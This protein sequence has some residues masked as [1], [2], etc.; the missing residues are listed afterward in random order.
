[1]L[2]IDMVAKLHGGGAWDIDMDF[3]NCE[4]DGCKTMKDRQGTREEGEIR[5]THDRLCPLWTSRDNSE[6]TKS[7]VGENNLNRNVDSACFR[8][9]LEKQDPYSESVN[10]ISACRDLS[11]EELPQTK[12]TEYLCTGYDLYI[13]RE[14][15][16]M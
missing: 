12:D 2:C 9:R 4:E 10:E 8:Q 1:M 3:A 16:V 15:C 13:T 7:Y 6:E 5:I 11:E 14:P